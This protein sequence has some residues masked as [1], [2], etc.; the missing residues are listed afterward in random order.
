Y[1]QAIEAAG[2][3]LDES[4]IVNVGNWHRSDGAEAMRAALARGLKFDGLV[5][6]ND[7]I[8]LGAMRVLQEAGIRIPED[9]AVIG[10]DD[11][12]ETRYSLPSLST[13]DPGREE[14]ART[15]VSVLMERIADPA[16]ERA[17]REYEADF[18]VV[19]RESTLGR[20]S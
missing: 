3:P 13:I 6:F 17:P 18:R 4:L 1:K 11:I 14:I 16:A 7:S 19:A 8:A 10:F 20:A 9:V 12:D 5:A 2:R 15:A